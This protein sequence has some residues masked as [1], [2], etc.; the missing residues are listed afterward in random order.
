MSRELGF[1][2]VVGGGAL[3]LFAVA[4]LNARRPNWS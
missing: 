2:V 3:V 1:W 4:V